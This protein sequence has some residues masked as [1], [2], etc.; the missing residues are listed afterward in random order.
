MAIQ[1]R[2]VLSHGEL[3]FYV[4]APGDRLRRP[5]GDPQPI[6]EDGFHLHDVYHIIFKSFLGYSHVYDVLTGA[7][8]RND[9][10]FL[11]EEAV[12]LNAFMC[13]TTAASTGWCCEM[14]GCPDVS[15]R[16]ME[17]ALS[18]CRIARHTLRKS[19]EL[20]NVARL[21]L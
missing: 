13:P 17:E 5:F 7:E 21:S 3:Y 11:R 1:T 16:R 6:R 19:L 15:L 10:A 8:E 4:Q 14:L 2:V 18:R 12:V 9:V 20:G